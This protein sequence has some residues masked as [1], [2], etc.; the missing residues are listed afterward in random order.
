MPGR[1]SVSPPA[2]LGFAAVTE[3]QHL[4]AGL[5][6][7][8]GR[9]TNKAAAKSVGLSFPTMKATARRTSHAIVFS[10]ESLPRT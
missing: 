3:N 9:I 7:H 1:R 10:S 8:R 4:C 5:N 2:N 6:V